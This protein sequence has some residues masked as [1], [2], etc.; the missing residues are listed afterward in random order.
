MTTSGT[1]ATSSG[2]VVGEHRNAGLRVRHRRDV[3]QRDQR[4]R[5]GP[6]K[7]GDAAAMACPCPV[8]PIERDPGAP[9]WRLTPALVP[10]LHRPAPASQPHRRVR[11]R[12]AGRRPGRSAAVV[13]EAGR[14]DAGK[15]QHRRDPG[16]RRRARDAAWRRG[17]SS[18]AG[19]RAAA[20]SRRRPGRRRSASRPRAR[21]PDRAGRLRSP[22]G[23][24]S[25]QASRC[26][27]FWEPSMATCMVRWPMAGLAKRSQHR[28]ART[29]RPRRR[30]GRAGPARCRSA[31]WPAQQPVMPGRL[32][33]LARWS[34]L[35]PARPG[36]P[37]RVHAVEQPQLEPLPGGHVGGEHRAGR[38]PGRAAAGERR[39]R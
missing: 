37:R 26:G 28:L 19:R 13:G 5:A 30:R 27:S 4:D 1:V 39:P 34:R 31:P 9:P 22:A 36:K 21:W 35:R 15:S 7:L 16:G 2:A 12:S 29:R 23:R 14:H 38:V 32:M 18:P 17:Y 11:V 10:P 8:A 6:R 20:P 24:R 3:A 25:V 33:R